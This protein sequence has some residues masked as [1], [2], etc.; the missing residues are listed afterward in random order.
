MR[1]LICLALLALAPAPTLAQNFEE[2]EIVVTG[3]RRD[4]DDYDETVP[5]V[6]LKRVADF[7]VQQVTVVGDTRDQQKR[8]DE[9]F[10]MIR[11]AID[12][13]ARRGDVELATGDMV[14]E[15]LTASN[16]RNLALTND[17]RPDTDGTTFLV[18]TRLGGTDTKAALDRIAA[19]IK[20][21][22]TVGRAEMRASGNLTLS[23][24]GPDQYRGRIVDLVAADA[25]ATAAKLGPDYAV[26][27]A[28]LDRPV[29]WARASLTEVFL[30]VP[31]RYTVVPARR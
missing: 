5:A 29:E 1:H 12:V 28:G 4:A 6:G 3:T 23:I 17:G 30:Y 10:A 18:K 9:I 7:A 31:Y 15:P 19:F 26:E 21:V 8:R 16:Y 24:V 27:A 13:A 20:A 22:P 11:G 14:V 25:R 2:G